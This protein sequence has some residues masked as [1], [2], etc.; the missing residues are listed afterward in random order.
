MKETRV[1]EV[2]LA[3]IKIGDEKCDK[4]NKPYWMVGIKVGDN[5]CNGFINEKQIDEVRKWKSGDGVLLAFF[6]NEKNGKTYTNFKFPDKTD[7]LEQR[8][9]V[10]EDQVKE[11]MSLVKPLG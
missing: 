3:A 7:L 6:Q 8:I 9:A 5:W 2:R 1:K 4:R 11:L 10:L